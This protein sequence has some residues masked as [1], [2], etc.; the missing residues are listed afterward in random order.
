MTVGSNETGVE[1][2]RGSMAVIA[3][4]A[5]GDERLRSAA[6]SAFGSVRDAVGFRGSDHDRFMRE[7]VSYLP[8]FA[9]LTHFRRRLLVSFETA[10]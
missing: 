7:C 8:D 4:F 5:A 1:R 10:V 2:L 6:I 9:M 3:N